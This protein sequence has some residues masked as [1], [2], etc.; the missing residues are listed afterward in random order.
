MNNYLSTE[1]VA[2]VTGIHIKRL[3]DWLYYDIIPRPEIEGHRFGWT[4]TDIYALVFFKRIFE[5]GYIR[6]IAAVYAKAFHNVIGNID[7]EVM[8]YVLFIDAKNKPLAVRIGTD[9]LIRLL[10]RD[11][12]DDLTSIHIYNIQEMITDVDKKLEAVT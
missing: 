8:N 4:I 6:N 1:Q 5:D 12:T 11:V 7:K 9:I 10:I 2:E 3:N